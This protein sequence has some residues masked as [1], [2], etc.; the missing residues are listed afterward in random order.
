MH[1]PTARQVYE[2]PD[3]HWSFITNPVDNEFE[4]Q[5]FDRKEAARPQRTG[6][7]SKG[8][9]DKLRTLVKKT[10]SAF[11]NSNV[12]GGLLVLGVS[13]TGTIEGIDHLSED[14]QNAVCDLNKILHHH[15][16]DVRLYQCQSSTGENKTIALIFSGWSTS[17]ICE[18]VGNNPQ[19]WTRNGKQCVEMTQQVRDNLRVRKGLIDFEIDPF[20]EFGLEDVDQDVLVEFRKV[21]LIDGPSDFDDIRVLKEAGAIV[22]KDGEYHFT[23]PGLLF[24]GKN[25]QRML[26]HAY[27]RLMRF[28]VVAA[29]YDQRGAPNL[30]KEFKG[31]ITSQIRA[32]RTYFRES[33]FFK[34]FQKRKPDG[35]FIEEPELPPVAIDE[36]IVNSVAHREYLTKIP[37]EC[38]AYLDAFIVKNPGRVT[39]RDIDLPDHFSL[40]TTILDSSPRNGKLLEWLKLMR[41]SEGRAFVQ[42]VSEGTKRMNAEMRE[43]KLPAP[44]FSL[45]ENQSL[46]SLKSNAQEREAAILAASI[47]YNSTESINF[48]PLIAR[49]GSDPVNVK[50]FRGRQGEFLSNLRDKL[51][52]KGWYIDRF[53]FGRLTTHRQGNSLPFAVRARDYVRLYPA[54]SIQFQEAFGRHY[55]CI[56]Y[57]CEVLNIKKLNEVIGYLGKEKLTDINCVA[58]DEGWSKGRIVEINDDWTLVR[59]FDSEH[60]KNIPTSDVIPNLSVKLIGSLLEENNVAID[61]HSEIKR[62]S[63]TTEKAAAR[64]RSEKIQQCAELIASDIFPIAFGEYE[65]VLDPTQL[66][67]VEQRRPGQVALAVE[68]L[69]EPEVEF[70]NSKATANVRDGITNFGSFDNDAHKIEIIPICIESFKQGM[71]NLIRRLMEGKFKYKGAERTFS[72]KFS[73]S[74]VITVSSPHD[75]DGEI[76]RLLNQNPEWCGDKGLSRV[77]LVH[78][79]EA[80][81]SS[82]DETSP[83]YVTKRR[84]LES[85]IPCQMVDSPTLKNP[86]WKDLNLA[87]NITAKCGVTPWVLPERIPDSDFFIGLSYTQSRSGQRIMGFANVFNNYGR[88]EFYAGNTTT[89]DAKQRPEHLACLL[90]EAL[91]RL[92]QKHSL[93]A[94]ANIVVHHS[95]RISREDRTA[96]LK[97]AR[98]VTPDMSITF[99]WVNSH[100]NTRLFDTRPET[101][102][103]VRRGSFVS[104]SRR[105]VVLSTTGTN[106][107]RRAMGTP[108]PIELNV[109][110]FDPHND[111]P[112]DYD[113]RSL[114]LQ[115]LSL[116]KLNWASTDAFCGEPITVDYASDIAYLTAAFIRQKEPFKLHQ[117]LES[118]PWFI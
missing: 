8:S 27:V 62:A 22:K 48:Y 112:T 91:K 111:K 32:A 44:E 64:T 98:L 61:L 1:H 26:S 103:S 118:T 47:S 113:G 52:A 96:I 105:S 57:R 45:T 51:A 108:R 54:Y 10:V 42:A 59:F 97:A 100:G 95:V 39:Q 9:L 19:A 20:C 46:L 89:F 23:V 13:S 31:P 14:Q 40:D 21:F 50:E 29:D 58:N 87:L 70:R 3:T 88:W 117:V 75:I 85:G 38:E 102:G 86:D 4:G 12:E 110:H 81:F 92:Q 60:E 6:Q 5:H 35:G 15:V 71:E 83:Y 25:P 37:I 94:S 77:F 84:L 78:C 33:G 99:V 101:D 63:L 68:R 16:T 73:Y 18:T 69:N 107:Y 24:F 53:S 90:Q 109:M 43:L 74:T 76:Q 115:V 2:D 49:K 114:A 56:D 82:D 106:P 55:L 30:N 11:A 65:V 80:G 72:T 36:A 104:L 116:T 66:P 34:R 7:V 93:P 17:G 67:L 41:D 79:P 28:G